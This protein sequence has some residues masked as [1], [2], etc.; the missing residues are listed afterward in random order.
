MR[1]GFIVTPNIS[2]DPQ[3]LHPLVSEA[4]DELLRS[5]GFFGKRAQR[6]SLIRVGEQRV[7]KVV[8]RCCLQCGAAFTP[9]MLLQEDCAACV[10]AWSR[11]VFESNAHY[12][13][14]SPED[15]RLAEKGCAQC[16][17]PFFPL[18]SSQV[19][20]ECCSPVP[21]FARIEHDVVF[22]DNHATQRV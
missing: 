8:D 10:E 9:V 1:T 4:V 22:A 7:D 21:S 14:F 2:G 20:G 11:E 16:G 12:D 6:R 18:N 13:G 15:L 3:A 17:Q 19:A 5:N